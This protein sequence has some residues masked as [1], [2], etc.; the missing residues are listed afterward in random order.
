METYN[1]IMRDRL[2]LLKKIFLEVVQSSNL[3][4]E[5]SSTLDRY[6]RLAESEFETF[7]QSLSSGGRYGS[8]VV[9]PSEFEME[10]SSFVL[11][12]ARDLLQQLTDYQGCQEAS[13]EA[14]YIEVVPALIEYY[15]NVACLMNEFREKYAKFKDELARRSRSS[16]YDLEGRLES[17]RTS[18]LTRNT[19]TYAAIIEA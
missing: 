7:Y 10:L 2:T 14:S 1:G 12:K 18:E 11:R 19:D 15:K 5:L 17:V 6:Q 16:G 13:D 4:R 3:I 9:S 8:F